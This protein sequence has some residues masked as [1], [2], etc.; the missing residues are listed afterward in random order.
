ML[1]CC[2]LKDLTGDR[3]PIYFVR[4]CLLNN[5]WLA[6]DLEDLLQD[7]AFSVTDLSDPPV[8]GILLLL[9]N[10][11]N[12][13]QPFLE[14]HDSLRSHFDNQNNKL[15][16]SIGHTWDGNRVIGISPMSFRDM[17]VTRKLYYYSRLK[18]IDSNLFT[19]LSLSTPK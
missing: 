14:G 10:N 4:S 12:P 5:P 1:Y 2:H 15:S 7:F 13:L 8:E 17:L 11:C 9:V 18:S 16:D 3:Y 6:W 19:S